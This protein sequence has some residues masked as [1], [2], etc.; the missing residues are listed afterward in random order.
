MQNNEIQ[1]WLRYVETR[2]FP[3]VRSG[4]SKLESML[5]DVYSFLMMKRRRGYR[6]ALVQSSYTKRS[7]VLLLHAKDAKFMIMPLL[8]EEMHW[9]RISE[10]PSPEMPSPPDPAQ[11]PL[12]T[13]QLIRAS[14]ASSET[15][16]SAT[17]TRAHLLALQRVSNRQRREWRELD[18]AIVAVQRM[19]MEEEIKRIRAERLGVNLEELRVEEGVA[20]SPPPGV[21]HGDCTVCLERLPDDA[22]E[23]WV[24]R[25]GAHAV[26]RPCGRL[27]GKACQ[28]HAP[29][30]ASVDEAVTCPVCRA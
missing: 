15:Q 4:A 30:G 5:A 11:L 19:E 22:R 29:R 28:K 1:D 24:M 3:R 10:V 21:M 6:W 27:W 23:V 8:K 14:P 7:T 25:C 16:R 17:F 13:A 20:A 9:R 26:C 18:D 2:E 12:P